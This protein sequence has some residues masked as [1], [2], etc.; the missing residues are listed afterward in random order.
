MKAILKINDKEQHTQELKRDSHISNKFVCRVWVKQLSIHEGDT[1]TLQI[2]GE[3]KEIL[4]TLTLYHK[5]HIWTASVEVKEYHSWG[6]LTPGFSGTFGLTAG[7]MPRKKKQS[8]GATPLQKAPQPAPVEV[9]GH[10][11]LQ[12]TFNGNAKIQNK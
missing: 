12:S 10:L 7:I 11:F 4:S 5:D 9:Q 6:T 1:V 8:T 3:S 2:V